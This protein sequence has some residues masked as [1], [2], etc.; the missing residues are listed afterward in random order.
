MTFREELEVTELKRALEKT[1]RSLAKSKAKTQ[2]MV[3]AV[4]AAAMEASLVQPHIKI[5][6][7]KTIKSNKAE[8][9][10]VHLTDWQAGKVS[11]SFNLEVLRK[12]IEQMVDKV[13]SL[14]EIQ[15]AHHPV[16]ECVLILGEI[17][18]RD[19]RY[20]LDNNGK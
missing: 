7:R 15:R 3:Y 12:R 16:N 2:D 14:T 1:Q 9:A 13:I 6:P 19:F 5:K 18:S 10:V 17:W 20:S 4:H 8:V 11:V